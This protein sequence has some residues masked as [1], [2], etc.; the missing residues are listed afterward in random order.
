M[1]RTLAEVLKEHPL[2]FALRHSRE[3]F[4]DQY[5]AVESLIDYPRAGL[6]AEVGTG[7]T[8]MGTCLALCWNAEVNVLIMPP[9]L[10][11]QWD[12]W[13]KSVGNIGSILIYRGTPAERKAMKLVGHKWVMMSI[14]ILKR[15]FARIKKELGPKKKSVLVDEAT[16]VKNSASQNHKAVAELA[17]DQNLALL[18]GTPLS[19]PHDAYGYV[20][21]ISPGVSRSKGQFDKLHVEALDHFGKVVKWT[22]LDRM[23][24]HPRLPRIRLL[25]DPVLAG[26]D[27]PP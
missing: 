16:S 24:Q 17:E 1:T 26:L 5:E 15:D 25:K 12:R 18:T 22:H 21:L 13:L 7:K 11:K 14:G 6:Y 19:T 9:I 4:L 27:H 8:A 10:L 23:Q 3:D 2:P 20:K